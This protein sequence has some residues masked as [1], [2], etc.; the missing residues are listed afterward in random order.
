MNVPRHHQARR[1]ATRRTNQVTD[2][3]FNGS[4]AAGGLY[5]ERSRCRR[6]SA[7]SGASLV[8]RPDKP[9]LSNADRQQP[10]REFHRERDSHVH[11][12]TI[13]KESRSES[14]IRPMVAR[15]YT[16]RGMR[17]S[18]GGATVRRRGPFRSAQLLPDTDDENAAR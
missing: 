13:H 18:I 17:M 14:G 12:G 8:R 7:G 16:R 3:A 10:H 15:G 2:T 11:A 1:V 4:P 5:D 9:M 6:M